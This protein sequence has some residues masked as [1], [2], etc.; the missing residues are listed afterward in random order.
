MNLKKTTIHMGF[1]KV[2]AALSIAMIIYMDG[3]AQAITGR[4]LSLQ[5]CVQTAITNNLD[6]KQSDLSMERAAVAW[7]QSK[8][9]L[10]PNISGEVDH[11]LN[12]GRSIDLSTNSYVDQQN[13]SGSYSLSGNVT[14]FNGLR[15][16]NT[17]KSNQ[18][19]YEAS[20]MELQQGKEQLMLNVIL[21]YLQVLT[22]SDL[23][24]QAQKQAD[25]TQKQVE[26][27][28]VMNEQGAIKPSDLS[29]LKGQLADNKV[30][31]IKSQNDLD[32]ARL[33]L[34]QLMNVP[35]DRNLQLEPLKADQ[36]D[37]NYAGT[38]DSIYQIS[39]QQLSII[40]AVDLR[41]K[42]AEKA[43]QAARGNLFPSVGL[44]AGFYTP[45]SSTARDSAA[46]KIGYYDQLSNNYRY[47]AGISISIPIFNNFLYRNKIALAKI[48]LKSAEYTA[49][50]REIQLKQFIEQ[51]YFNMTAALR[52]YQVLV[53]QVEAYSE[54]FRAAE[55]RYN[56]GASTSV[57]YIIAENNL[58]RAN[59]N[60]IIA[61]Y[62]YVLRTKIL[63]YYQNKPLW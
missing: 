17:L 42:S 58:A 60:L 7:R 59:V 3:R 29:D 13:T 47:Y 24:V 55:V 14:L 53:E 37:M 33:A 26:R 1:S 11:T 23:V 54:S 4:P 39:L 18:F 15:L 21:A 52:R 12:R 35:Y 32:A 16:L 51:D 61:R 49:H 22:D 40:K 28:Q 45:Y 46:Q 63:D 57:D 31:L 62:D 20:K 56:A 43:V 48:D 27:L 5:E 2:F 38:P 41:K 19:A 36:F 34:A 10:L 8:A 9:N 25:V 30:T 6:V 44:G 50:T